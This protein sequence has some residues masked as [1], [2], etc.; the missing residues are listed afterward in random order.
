MKGKNKQTSQMLK[1]KIYIILKIYQIVYLC[2]KS[3][4]IPSPRPLLQKFV[5][6]FS[7]CPTT[8]EEIR[9]VSMTRDAFHAVQNEDRNELKD[10]FCTLKSVDTSSCL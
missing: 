6:N 7:G 1:P 10:L 9:A 4:L 8:M 2:K 3:D 5:S